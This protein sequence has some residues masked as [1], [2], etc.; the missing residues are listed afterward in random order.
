M[1]GSQADYLGFAFSFLGTRYQKAQRKD[2]SFPP[3]NVCPIPL[4][5][6]L[7]NILLKDSALCLMIVN[8]PNLCLDIWKNE[9]CF[10]EEISK[11]RIFILKSRPGTLA[12]VGYYKRRVINLRGPEEWES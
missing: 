6:S 11:E 4:S 12:T 7:E 3:Q 1:S 10:G 9:I 2:W 8:Q 5:F